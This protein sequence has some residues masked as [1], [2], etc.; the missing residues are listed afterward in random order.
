MYV[1]ERDPVRRMALRIFEKALKT[2]P[3][4]ARSTAAGIERTLYRLCGSRTSEEYRRRVR[5]IGFNLAADGAAALREAVISETMS[6]ERLC[7][8]PP[9]SL[10]TPAL[11]KERAAEMERR[12]KDV[13]AITAKDLGYGAR[14]ADGDVECR[15]CHRKNT[16]VVMAQT[17]SGDE[18]MTAF[19]YCLNCKQRWKM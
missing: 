11:K 7:T 10:A 15:K 13:C 12:T 4:T 16:E 18:S 14:D 8:A 9:R 5:S 2:N 3:P 19:I 17:R 6:Y 1:A